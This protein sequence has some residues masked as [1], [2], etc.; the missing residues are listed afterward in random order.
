MDQEAARHV[1]LQLVRPG[2]NTADT[3]RRATFAELGDKVRPV[4][5]ALDDARLLVTGR[6]EATEEQT[7]EVAHEALIRHWR[8]LRSWL[9]QD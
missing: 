8:R 4:V 7:L 9:D 3:R 1:F 5:H 2:E 6:D